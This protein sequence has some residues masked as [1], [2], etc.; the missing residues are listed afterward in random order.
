MASSLLAQIPATVGRA[1]ILRDAE[2][3]GTPDFIQDVAPDLAI[4]R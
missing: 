4:S 1:L 3:T 2:F